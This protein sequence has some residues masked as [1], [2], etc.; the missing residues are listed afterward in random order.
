M[1]NARLHV[2][3]PNFTPLP[4]GLFSAVQWRD[5]ADPHWRLGI[6]YEP[7]CGGV[8]T[9][10]E[11][12]FSV[13]GSGGP[14][15]PP[16]AKTSTGDF[17]R[18]GATAF[19]VYSDI[20]CS[21]PGFWDRAESAAI[22]L[23][24][25]AEQR[26]VER[27][28]WTGVA[29]LQPVVYPHLA[30]DTAFIENDGQPGSVTLQTA[31]TVVTGSILDVVEGLGVLEEQLAL[32]YDGVG[33]IHV[34]LSVIPPLVEAMQLQ[35]VGGKLFT[36]NGNQVVAGA[37]YPGTSPSGADPAVGRRWIYATGALIGYRSP[38]KLIG[39]NGEILNRTNDTVEAR[40]ERT[41]VIGWECC[42]FAL[43][44]STGGLASGTPGSPS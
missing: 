21:A 40:A 10:Y 29:G 26:Q 42:H 6:T 17:T 35:R 24:G 5:D 31:A 43:Q 30:E 2:P 33:V 28:L 4:Y 3:A 32:C 14:P 37:G 38:I 9:T 36:V 19:T 20:D 39:T 13:T 8:G 15:P 25:R 44:V 11:G 22:E 7:L 1:V 41:Y 16:P 18:R 23:V 27:A 34:P 12:C